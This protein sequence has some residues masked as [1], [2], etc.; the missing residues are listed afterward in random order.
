MRISHAMAAVLAGFAVQIATAQQ[1]PPPGGMGAPISGT[2][3]SAG[4]DQIVLTTPKGDVTVSVTPKTQVFASQ[5]ASAS[6]IKPGSY[7]GTSNQ[8]SASPNT[9]TASEIH[10]GDNGPNVNSPMNNSGL[11]MTNGHVKAVSLT[12][13]G[14]ELDIDYGQPTLRHVVVPDST[15]IT[16]MV[17]ARLSDLKPG[18]LLNAMTSTGAD[19][20]P[21]AN[22]IM[23]GAQPV[24]S[25]R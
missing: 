15:R 7:L 11:T 2:L 10:L 18:V 16:K 13:A 4:T 6:D 23:V 22:M 17:N 12:K 14:A 5:A 1:G 20:K 24:P 25:S 3:K 19:G 21:V 8:N 9:G